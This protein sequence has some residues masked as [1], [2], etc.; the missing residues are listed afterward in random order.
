[1]PC[2]KRKPK[3]K[4]KMETNLLEVY[5]AWCHLCALRKDGCSPSNKTWVYCGMRDRMA[6]ALLDR[7]ESQTS[8]THKLIHPNAIIPPEGWDDK[9]KIKV[10]TI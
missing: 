6:D 7:Y 4:G 5:G 8:L 2:G 9:S 3:P 1:M 10:I